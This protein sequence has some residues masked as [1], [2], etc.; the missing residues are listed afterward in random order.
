MCNLLKFQEMA[1]SNSGGRSCSTM[2]PMA[3]LVYC[4]MTTPDPLFV[5]EQTWRRTMYY[6]VSG[7]KK[8]STCISQ[9]Y[10]A[11]SANAWLL[12]FKCC[13]YD[14]A[15]KHSPG[16]WYCAMILFSPWSSKHVSQWYTTNL[17]HLNDLLVCSVEKVLIKTTPPIVQQGN[18]IC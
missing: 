12:R 10:I 6:C 8:W 5:F 15:A 17:K 11:L 16:S 1:Y 3:Y 2:S 7:R 9:L 4:P 14:V 13:W 18:C